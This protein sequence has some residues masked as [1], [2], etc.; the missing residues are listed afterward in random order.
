[1]VGMETN[2][3]KRVFKDDRFHDIDIYRNSL[4]FV[5]DQIKVELTELPKRNL[6]NWIFQ[7]LG[8]LHAYF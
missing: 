1:M 5:R 4:V 8:E 2:M 6:L 7:C 3:N